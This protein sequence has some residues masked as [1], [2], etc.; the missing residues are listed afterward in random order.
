MFYFMM[1]WFFIRKNGELLSKLV[2]A[3][4]L[5]IGLQCVKDLFF[6]PFRDGGLSINWMIMTASDMVAVPLY[7]FI[8]IEL[9]RPDTLTR[10]QI[11]LCAGKRFLVRLII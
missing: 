5:V 8:L 3:L 6:I 9:C 10:R 2:A 1:T 11:R 4:M 7:A